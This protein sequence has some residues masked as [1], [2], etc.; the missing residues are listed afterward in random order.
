MLSPFPCSPMIRERLWKK[1]QINKKQKKA[2]K[3]SPFDIAECIIEIGKYFKE[4]PRNIKLVISGMLPRGKCWSVSRITN[5]IN[6]ILADKFSFR[7]FFFICQK[8]GKTRK[9]YM[10]KVGLSPSKK[11]FFIC[12]NDSPSKMM[13]NA[14][15]FILKALFVLR[16]FKF[17]SWHFRH[18]EKTTWLEG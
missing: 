2:N 12:F 16:I 17:L 1:T 11:N 9:N 8:Y 13:K 14:F 18:V 5:D 3:D 7:G 6:D 4:K 10:L 15:Y